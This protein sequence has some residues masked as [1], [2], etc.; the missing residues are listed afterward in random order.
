TDHGH[1]LHEYVGDATPGDVR[2]EGV[3]RL[4][5]R[6]YVL[7]PAT[8]PAPTEARDRSC[9]RLDLSHRWTATVSVPASR[10]MTTSTPSTAIATTVSC[11]R[12]AGVRGA[13]LEGRPPATRATN[14]MTKVD[15]F[16]VGRT[17]SP[18]FAKAGAAAGGLAF[19]VGL[20]A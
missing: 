11:V 16:T 3:D 15:A 18:P 13:G 1:P 20:S 7:G 17:P 12:R 6:W 10:T 19:M 9:G 5:A 8:R 14:A 4:G 2:G